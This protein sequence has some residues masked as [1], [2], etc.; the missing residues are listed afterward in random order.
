VIAL[1]NPEH[2]ARHDPLSGL[3]LIEFGADDDQVVVTLDPEAVPALIDRLMKARHASK[4]AKATPTAPAAQLMPDGGDW[5]RSRLHP[6]HPTRGEFP[7]PRRTAQ[8]RNPI[9]ESVFC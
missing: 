2:S 1:V 5:C 9:A 4:L 6:F 3:V 8:D 7:G